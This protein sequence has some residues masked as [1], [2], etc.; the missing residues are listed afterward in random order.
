MPPLMFLL[1]VLIVGVPIARI[2]RRAGRSR[3]WVILAFVPLLNLLGLWLFAFL[4]WPTLDKS[5][6]H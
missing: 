1:F 5:S 6:G 4:R 2:L 3:W